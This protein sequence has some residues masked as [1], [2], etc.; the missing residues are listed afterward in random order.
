M[1]PTRY[2]R[3]L[4]LISPPVLDKQFIFFHPNLS[5][6]IYCDWNTIRCYCQ[7]QHF[8]DL[9]V[10]QN[11]PRAYLFK[12]VII[13]I[14]NFVDFASR[15][16]CLMNTKKIHFSSLIFSNNLPSTCFKQ[17]DNS[18]SGGSYCMCSIWCLSCIC[19]D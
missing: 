1:F 4:F 7:T 9:S 17:S 5:R 8:A 6:C 2:I 13:H 18:S 10:R 3:I 16:T 15:Y 12:E 14:S 11:R 19:V